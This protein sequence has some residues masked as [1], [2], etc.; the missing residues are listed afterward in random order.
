MTTTPFGN[1]GQRAIQVAD[2]PN[3]LLSSMDN[4]MTSRDVSLGFGAATIMQDIT[5]NIPKGSITALVGPSG[6]GKTTFLRSLNRLNDRVPGFWQRGVITLNDVDINASGVDPLVL[7]RRVGMVFQRP[8]PFPMSILD[9][10]VAGVKAHKL[11]KRSQLRDIAETRLAEVGL[12]SRISDRLD[13][14]PFRLS[15]GQQQLLCLARALAVEPEVLLLDEPTSSLDPRSTEA[16]EELIRRLTPELTV[17]IVTHNLDQARRLSDNTIFFYEGR[18]M[19]TGA[20]AQLF[21]SPQR[22]ETSRYLGGAVTVNGD[23]D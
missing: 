14:S 3:S 1:T 13:D 5:V 19:E 9:N 21:S 11:A 16:V 4:I 7:R 23:T 18:L 12:W 6:S 15:G 2:V 22:Q 20:T 17:I 8:N 10:V